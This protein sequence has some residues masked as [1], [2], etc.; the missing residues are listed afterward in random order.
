MGIAESESRLGDD[1]T[2]PGFC[3]DKGISSILYTQS[4]LTSVSEVKEHP[5]IGISKIV[6]H[7]TEEGLKFYVVQI[8]GAWIR[9]TGA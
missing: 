3:I 9:D 7:T 8:T 4:L 2:I 1:A 6:K 5:V